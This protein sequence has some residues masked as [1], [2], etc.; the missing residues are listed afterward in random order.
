MFLLDTNFFGTLVH[1]YPDDVFP[2]LW[3]RLETV[4]FEDDVFYHR[5]VHEESKRWKAPEAQWYLERVDKSRILDTNAAELARYR[6]VANWAEN[7]REPHYRRRA[8]DEFLYAAD[9]WLVAAA[10]AHGAVIVTEEVPAPDS[11][12]K[13]KIPDAAQ[14]FGV[15]CVGILDFLRTKG[16]A[17]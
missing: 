2:S 10:A 3:E 7:E 13:V 11:P 15:R 17:I 16:V 8:V 9:S 1:R 14:A 12:K 4:A 5:K 6:E